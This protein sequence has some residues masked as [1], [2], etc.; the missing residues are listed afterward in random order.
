MDWQCSCR[1]G[2]QQTWG[3][4]PDVFCT[5]HRQWL[6]QPQAVG[7][8]HQTFSKAPAPFVTHHAVR[9]LPLPPCHQGAS[10]ACG[11]QEPQVL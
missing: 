5:W 9:L 8:L 7:N 1:A 6:P 11:R 4:A 10:C 2:L 3:G